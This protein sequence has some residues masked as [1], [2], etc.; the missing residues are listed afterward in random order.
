[1]ADC[2]VDKNVEASGGIDRWSVGVFAATGTQVPQAC[3]RTCLSGS[4]DLARTHGC[5][6]IRALVDR[7]RSAD[8]A[9]P[10]TAPRV[11]DRGYS[12]T[13]TDGQGTGGPDVLVLRAQA[14]GE[15][16]APRKS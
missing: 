12:V 5:A 8:A 1:M 13:W 9:S 2:V 10:V 7:T 6:M 11:C 14:A 3:L 15:E 16:V 4:T